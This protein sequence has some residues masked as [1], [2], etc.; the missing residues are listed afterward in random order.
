MEFKILAKIPF[1]F[2]I[3]HIKVYIH[4]EFTYIENICLSWYLTFFLN[5]EIMLGNYR[6]RISNNVS[7]VC[8]YFDEFIYAK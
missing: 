5:I 2:L 7:L 4:L 1:Q 8:E 6:T 3:G